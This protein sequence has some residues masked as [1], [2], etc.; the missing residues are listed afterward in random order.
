MDELSLATPSLLFPAI[1]LLMLAYTNRFLALSTIIRQLYDTHRRNPHVNNL[2]QIG[3]FRRRVALIRGMQA[4][5][6]VSLLSCI[7]SMVLVFFGHAGPAQ[8]LFIASL[9]LMVLS[10]LLCLAEVLISDAA[11][12]I[13]LQDIE[14]DL[15]RLDR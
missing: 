6:V 9:A 14:Q 15:R 4:F 12:N 13:L 1:S 8:F 11:L 7:V 10:L 3:N 2:R 5:G